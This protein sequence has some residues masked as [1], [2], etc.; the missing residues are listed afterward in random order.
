MTTTEILSKYTLGEVTIDE[1]NKEL[2]AI[3]SNLRL[4][5][6]KNFILPNEVTEYGLLNSGWGDLDKTKVRIE[7]EDDMGDTPAT[8][9]FMGKKFKVEGKRL[10]ELR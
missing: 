7:L 10:I 6:M 4:N 2:E 5:P 9:I 3:G 1:V 8:C